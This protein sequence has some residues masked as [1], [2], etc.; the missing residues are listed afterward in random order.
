M[1]ELGARAFIPSP[2]NPGGALKP[3]VHGGRLRYCSL[4]PLFHERA[5]GC[6]QSSDSVGEERAPPTDVTERGDAKRVTEANRGPTT[7]RF[8]SLQKRGST[9]HALGEQLHA[10]GRAGIS[11]VLSILIIT[12]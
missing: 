3:K 9:L 2:Q 7:S 10:S 8:Q 12:L 6:S 11:V 4:G 1:S 5:A